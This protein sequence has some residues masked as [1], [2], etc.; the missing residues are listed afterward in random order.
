MTL[1]GIG[2][3]SPDRRS[4]TFGVE[5]LSRRLGNFG[6]FDL[7]TAPLGHMLAIHNRL[8][9]VYGGRRINESTVLL[10]D[11]VGVRAHS[12]VDLASVGNRSERSYGPTGADQVR[13]RRFHHDPVHRIE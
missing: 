9:A 11:D 3:R 8:L 7:P 12:R 6:G 2:G 5:R 13:V 1:V 4:R 10:S